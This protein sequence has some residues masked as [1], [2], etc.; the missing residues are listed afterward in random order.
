VRAIDIVILQIN[1]THLAKLGW[2][3][4]DFT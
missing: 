3:T 4:C 1:P 2:Y